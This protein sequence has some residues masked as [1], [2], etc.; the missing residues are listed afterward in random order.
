MVGVACTPPSI[1]RGILPPLTPCRLSGASRRKPHACGAALHCFNA[2]RVPR[3]A[4]LSLVFS[5]GVL[6]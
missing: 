2:K 4:E 5:R 6:L 3:G 1:L